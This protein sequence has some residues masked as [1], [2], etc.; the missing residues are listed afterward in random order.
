MKNVP[1][2][3]HTNSRFSITEFIKEQVW[4]VLK[5]KAVQIIIILRKY[6]IPN[7]IILPGMFTSKKVQSFRETLVVL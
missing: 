4:K 1:H 7:T 3:L 6:N 5:S 2:M